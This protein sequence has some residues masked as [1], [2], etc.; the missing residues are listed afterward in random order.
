MRRRAGQTG[1][2]QGTAKRV[3][4]KLMEQNTSHKEG[5][6]V[7]LKEA[8]GRVL[9][10]YTTHLKQLGRMTRNYK[11]IKYAQIILSAIST[12]GFL[13]TIISSK[14]IATWIGGGSSI[15]LFALNLYFKNFN[16]AEEIAQH[17]EAADELWLIREQYI[18]LLTDLDVLTDEVIAAKR[19]ELQ[20]NTYEIYKKCPKT[21]FKSYQD[22]RKALK[23][24]EEQF[25]T[26]EEIDKMLPSHLRTNEKKVG[27]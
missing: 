26:T 20:N 6:R 16:F 21:D 18:S 7:Q 13:G 8:Y 19:D 25:F 10:T 12:G 4:D 11:Y 23:N 17:R 2:T 1:R 9:Y 27:Q 22:T 14:A 24:E 5:L 3:V 15:I